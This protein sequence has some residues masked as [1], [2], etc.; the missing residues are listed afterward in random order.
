MTQDRRAP[1]PRIEVLVTKVD[2]IEAQLATNQSILQ[3]IADVM[4]SFR[5]FSNVMKW[6]AAV[7]AAGVAI[8][9]SVKVIGKD[10]Q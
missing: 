1:D 10:M 3:D 9:H 2:R 8:W 5:V 4:A 6:A 7:L